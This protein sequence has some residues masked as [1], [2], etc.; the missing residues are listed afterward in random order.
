M[1]V[2][3]N[4]MNILIQIK[5]IISDVLNVSISDLEMGSSPDNTKNWD[6]IKHMDIIASLEE[7]FSI[8]FDEEEIF[9]MMNLE[10]I[11]IIIQEK[12]AIQKY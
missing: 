2:F 1:I 5:K 9:E 12:V 3:G 4:R 11:L 10:I 7:E 8:T 6:S